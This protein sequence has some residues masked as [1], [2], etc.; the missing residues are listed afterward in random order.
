MIWLPVKVEEGG[1]LPTYATD[2][3]AAMDM[4]A[5][6]GGYVYPNSRLLIPLDIR[7]EIPQGYCGI[8]THRSSMDAKGITAYGL[9]DADYR[10]IIKVTLHNT[11]SYVYRF[12]RGDRIAQ[13]RVV[14]VPEVRLVEVQ[15]MSLETQRG[16]GGHGSTGV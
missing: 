8:L 4:Y 2:G 14:R 15:G 7:M 12:D 16:E 6:A 10:G 1:K 9:I 5:P 11:G 3:S 13:M